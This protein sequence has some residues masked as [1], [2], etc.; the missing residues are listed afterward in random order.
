MVKY[1]IR[2]ISNEIR[3][4]FVHIRVTTNRKLGIRPGR[5]TENN[6]NGVCVRALSNGLVAD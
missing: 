1:N 2:F 4:Q 3:V 5:P 6:Q